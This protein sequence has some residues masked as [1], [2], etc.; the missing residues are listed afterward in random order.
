M[1]HESENRKQDV[2]PMTSP[3]RRL[4]DGPDAPPLF[5]TH[6]LGGDIAELS[7][8]VKHLRTARPIYGVQWQG[9]DGVERPHES[10]EEMAECFMDA[11]VSLNP[12]GP[13]LLAGLSIGGL[14]MLEMASRLLEQRKDVALL[15]L[16]DTYPHPRYW[17]L[18]CWVE[19]AIRRAKYQAT[20]LTKMP[21]RSAI[22]RLVE[23][24]GAFWNQ[25]RSRGGRYSQ[26]HTT[27]DPGVSLGLQRL[28]ECA[29]QAS[30]QYRPRYYPGKI[31]FL[32]A[33][34][35]STRFPENPARIWGS[36]TADLEI[37][38]IPCNHV[39]MITTDAEQVA[40]RLSLCIE[41]ALNS[42][43]RIR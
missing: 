41:K 5:I 11:I 28:Q 7:E 29:F 6:G 31:S 13:Y 34:I 40:A 38:T 4:K 2:A 15:A 12:N 9:L 42:D 18:A 37:N 10:I 1:L 23:L 19:V 17:P 3:L 30:A 35:L 26:F 14:P 16:L 33:G 24:S 20:A 25:F 36:L 32:R 43:T 27:I 22:L 39:A 8:V 21:P